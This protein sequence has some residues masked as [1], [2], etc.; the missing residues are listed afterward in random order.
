MDLKDWIRTQPLEKQER[1]FM[2]AARFFSNRELSDIIR[3]VNSGSSLY[4]AHLK[5]GVLA[6]YAVDLNNLRK[7]L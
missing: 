7:A 5:S 1:F 2:K 3:Y 6:R 4:S